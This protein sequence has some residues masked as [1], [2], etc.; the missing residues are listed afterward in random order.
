MGS[1]LETAI[2]FTLCFV[3]LIFLIVSPISICAD[4]VDM[5]NDGNRELKYHLA[6]E[7]II[8]S[9]RIG[10]VSNQS[11]SPERL[12]TFL[13]GVS[14]NYRMIYGSLTEVANEED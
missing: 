4:S 12:N 2:I 1:T 8:A 11:T 7:E 9:R 14:E 13:A 5:A 6:D 10:G 3:L